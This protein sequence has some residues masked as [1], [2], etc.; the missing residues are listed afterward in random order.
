M[1]KDFFLKLH[2][3]E[4]ED[5]EED[6]EEGEPR[7]AQK[8]EEGQRIT[9]DIQNYKVKGDNRNLTDDTAL[10]GLN[11]AEIV[12]MRNRGAAGNEIIDSLIQNS[13]TY[14]MKTQ[15]SKEKWLKKK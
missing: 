11:E 4:D 9:T 2:G 6:K 12:E 13:S 7:K 8:T 5:A 15:F 14:H 3:D 10:Q 1:V